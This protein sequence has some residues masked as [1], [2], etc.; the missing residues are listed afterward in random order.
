M[1]VALIG[2]IL[3]QVQ[4]H[5]LGRSAAAVR[6]AGF[7]AGILPFGGF[8]D[9]EAVIGAVMKARPRGLAVDSNSAP[10]PGFDP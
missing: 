7:G 3:P 9:I 10:D 1:D 5:T 2:L 4:N 6:L 8:A